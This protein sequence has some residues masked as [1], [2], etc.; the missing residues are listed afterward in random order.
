[1]SGRTKTRVQLYGDK[2]V[3][4]VRDVGVFK[5]AKHLS[6]L[7]LYTNRL[8]AFGTGNGKIFNRQ[9]MPPLFGPVI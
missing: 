6:L 5:P 2:A 1:M 7:V 8:S 9:R 3:W 4:F